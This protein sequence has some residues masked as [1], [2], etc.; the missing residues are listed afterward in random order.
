M[1]ES[2]F[3]K[4]LY[5]SETSLKTEKLRF[6]YLDSVRA[7]LVCF[8]SRNSSLNNLKKLR[9]NA[10]HKLEREL[11]IVKFLKDHTLMKTIIRKTT[12]KAERALAKRTIAFIVNE[13]I[14]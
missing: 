3:R 7:M 11:D 6:S 13:S 2:V 8:R 4:R 5:D 14:P 10:V 12:S 1:I 9:N